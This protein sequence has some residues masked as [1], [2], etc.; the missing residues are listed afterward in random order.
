MEGV[1]VLEG[2]SPVLQRRWDNSAG[3][4][5]ICR[6]IPCPRSSNQIEDKSRNT[7]AV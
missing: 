4:R 1:T 7:N 5:G 2:I 3:H 6:N